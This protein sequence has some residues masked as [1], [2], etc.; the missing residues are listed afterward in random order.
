MQT[1]KCEYRSYQDGDFTLDELTDAER[2]LRLTVNRLGA[3][4]IS[5]ARQD[6]EGRWQG[7]LYRDGQPQQ[8]TEGWANHATVM[9]YYLHRLWEEKSEYHGHVIRGG[10]HGFLR[11]FQFGAPVEDPGETGRLVY[12]VDPDAIPK[13]AYPYRVGMD[14]AYELADGKVTVRFLFRNEETHPCEVSFGMHPGFAVASVEEARILLPKGT[15]RRYLAPG[16][17]LN[18]EVLDI[19]HEGGPMPF[20]KEKLPDSYLL[21]LDL[22]PDAVL[23]LEDPAS[24]RTV[25]LDFSEVPFMTLW[26]DLGPMVCIEPCWG[27]PD[28]NPPTPFQQKIGIQVIDAGSELEASFSLSPGVLPH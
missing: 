7:Y 5:L 17:F 13:E 3:E 25:D 23:R 10:N 1:M 27:L 21:S 20:E 28:S 11:H 16:N 2:G 14:L 24:G 22:V 8:P 15:Y 19:V 26:S 18:G 12:R 4:M 6:D 9:G